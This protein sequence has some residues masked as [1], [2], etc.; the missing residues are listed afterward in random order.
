MDEINGTFATHC[1]ENRAGFKGKRSGQSP[2]AS[3]KQ[4]EN[5]QISLRPGLVSN[6]R[7]VSLYF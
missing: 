6:H 3:T 7:S 2:G 5:P 4:T 1:N